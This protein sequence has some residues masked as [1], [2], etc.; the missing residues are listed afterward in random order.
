MQ[1]T[2]CLLAAASA[3]VLLALPSAR[4]APVARTGPDGGVEPAHAVRMCNDD[5]DCWW[6]NRHPGRSDWDE[7]HRG[8]HG[9]RDRDDDYYGRGGRDRDWDRD[10]WRGRSERYDRH[11]SRDRD[12]W[13]RSN[14][15]HGRDADHDHDR[16]R[17]AHDETSRDHGMKEPGG[18]HAPGAQTGPDSKKD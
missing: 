17:N 3:A 8:R 9:W 2:L 5:G 7:D 11:G 18:V 12:D 10:D 6:S 14:E 15:R 13:G 16:D 1:K 4:P